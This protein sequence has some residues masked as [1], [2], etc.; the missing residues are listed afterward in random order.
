MILGL[1]FFLIL[2]IPLIWCY[3]LFEENLRFILEKTYCQ[4]TFKIPPDYYCLMTK[5]K[6]QKM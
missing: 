6:Y 4:I 2:I 3:G 1:L 5:N